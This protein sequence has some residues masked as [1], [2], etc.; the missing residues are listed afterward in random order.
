MRGT[1]PDPGTELAS[2]PRRRVDTTAALH[3]PLLARGRRV[4]AGARHSVYSR[5]G[6]A[7]SSEA[8][9]RSKRG[10]RLVAVALLAL[11]AG[12]L[13]LMCIGAPGPPPGEGPTEVDSAAPSMASSIVHSVTANGELHHPTHRPHT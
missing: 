12:T 4:P 3:S 10:A 2:V 13:A 9:G 5:A 6:A 8:K 7:D 1:P 11:S